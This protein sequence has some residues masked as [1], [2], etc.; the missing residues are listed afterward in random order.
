MCCLRHFFIPVDSFCFY[1]VQVIH[2]SS[3]TLLLLVHGVDT[4]VPSAKSLLSAFT[5]RR[6]IIGRGGQPKE[7]PLLL[8]PQFDS[9]FRISE[10]DCC[11]HDFNI[12]VVSCHVVFGVSHGIGQ[13]NEN[14][15]RRRAYDCRI[16]AF[17]NIIKDPE[18]Y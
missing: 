12:F 1:R 10:R 2:V 5:A 6:H 7:W 14:K 8:R 9:N 4:T 3:A 13:I 16:C 11:N 18:Y 15:Q 17:V